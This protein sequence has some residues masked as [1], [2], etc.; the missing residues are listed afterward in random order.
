MTKFVFMLSAYEEHGAID[1]VIVERADDLPAAIN[2]HPFAEGYTDE[3]QRGLAR[4]MADPDFG[5]EGFKRDL[6]S[7]WGGIQLHVVPVFEP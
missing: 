2:A 4:V 7:G 5:V 1:P 6:A 3:Y